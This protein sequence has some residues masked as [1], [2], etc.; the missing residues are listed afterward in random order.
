MYKLCVKNLSTEHIEQTRFLDKGSYTFGRTENNQIVLNDPTVSSAHGQIRVSEDGV[1][2]SDSGS[3]NQTY[4]G[5][6]PIPPY[7][8]TLV[9]DNTVTVGLYELTLTLQLTS[10]DASSSRDEATKQISKAFED[11]VDA[12]KATVQEALFKR[13]DLVRL[14]AQQIGKEELRTRARTTVTQIVQDMAKQLPSGKSQ[15]LMTKEILDEALGLGPLEEL[16]ADKN[17]TEIMVIS[18]DH[19]YVEKEG[20]IVLSSARFSSVEHLRHAIERI[21]TSKGRRIDEL[22]PYADTRLDDGS[23]VNAVIPPIAIDSPTL[24]IR[25]F[26]EK[27]F[28][29]E[30]LTRFGSCTTEMVDFLRICI[31]HR[32]STVISGGTG[33]GK[34]TLLN[35]LASFVPNNERLITIEDSAEL[36]LPQ[37]HVVRLEA[38]PPN[39]EGR[40]QV[41]IRDLVKNCLRMRPDRI[42]VGE[43]RGGEAIDML[44]AMNTGHDGSMT[45][46]HANSPR[47]AVSRLVTMCLMSDLELPT[48]SI[49]E[50]IASAVSLIVQTT[51]M[52]DGTRKIIR[53]CEVTGINQDGIILEDIFVFRESGHDESGKILGHFVCENTDPKVFKEL[54]EQK[55]EVSCMSRGT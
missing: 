3:T 33:S 41:L 21:V 50:Q 44:Q 9:G 13:L 40:G 48:R 39:I 54:R 11:E 2:V 49:Q 29:I 37:E 51:R 53:I 20:K 52:A 31:K 34:T 28:D 15:E 4:I 45:T 5:R 1:Y 32:K 6:E 17:I 7:N 18:R 23:R 38:R 26:P 42:I 46:L 30:D 25:K 27:R 47:D 43:C 55:I 12:F 19:I 16:L 8:E 35:A 22:H 24:T 10:T 14:E 36:N